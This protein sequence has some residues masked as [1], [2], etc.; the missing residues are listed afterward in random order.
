[1]RWLPGETQSDS[2]SLPAIEEDETATPGK[3][4]PLKGP[5]R[6]LLAEDNADMRAYVRRLLSPHMEVT[7]AANGRE[8]LTS[9]L[10]NPPDLVLSDVMMPVLDGFALLKEIRANPATA[11]LPVILLSARAGEE[12]CV[13]GVGAGAD[14]YLVKPFSARELL[15]RV[16]AH[17]KMSRLRRESMEALGQANA[18]LRRLNE[19]LNQF[20]YSASHDLQEPL[21]NISIFGQLLKQR[22]GPTADAEIREFLGFMV[23]GASRMETL[24]HDLLAYTQIASTATSQGYTD[25]N[26]ALRNAQQNLKAAI[27]ES[28]AAIAA[29]ELPALPVDGTHLHQLFQNLIGNALKYRDPARPSRVHVGVARLDSRWQ[30]VVEDNGIGIAP[31]YHQRVFGLFKRLH[32]ADKY[33][34]TGIGLAIAQKIVQRYGGQIWVESDL[35]KGAAFFF[36]L[37]AGES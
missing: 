30:F 16:S 17:L 10:E 33:S 14:D 31:E 6:I 24:L 22:F 8:A 15:A 34:G 27:A 25:A 2:E 35:G 20:A 4:V 9:I 18:E 36:T 3:A 13:E 37:P 7:A 21:R 1:L 28:G 29:E 23:E 11:T 5:Y 26:I 12:S 32:S 19:D